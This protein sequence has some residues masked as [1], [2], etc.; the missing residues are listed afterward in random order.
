[1]KKDKFLFVK[2]SKYGFS[3][4]NVQ[5]MTTYDGIAMSA[6]VYFEGK[7]LGEWYDDGCS[8][9]PNL[10]P[11]ARFFGEKLLE[12]HP[13]VG[14]FEYDGEVYACNDP[15]MALG[16]LLCELADMVE[17]G[18]LRHVGEPLEGCDELAEEAHS[19][20]AKYAAA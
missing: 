1:M 2:H 13:D 15:E 19:L 16:S 5:S 17:A 9:V 4:N 12:Q 3:L 10:F 14:S 6:D 11:L 8:I 7:L 18:D 20:W